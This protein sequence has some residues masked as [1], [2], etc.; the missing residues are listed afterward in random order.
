MQLTLDRFSGRDAFEELAG[1]PQLDA[2]RD[3][4]GCPGEAVDVQEAKCEME[5]ESGEEWLV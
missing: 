3:R 4:C 1:N 5:C 2:H